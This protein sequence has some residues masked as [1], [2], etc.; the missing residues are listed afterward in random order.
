MSARDPVALKPCPFCKGPPV[1]FVKF[2]DARGQV[3]RDA[4]IE[5]QPEGLFAEAQVFCHECGANGPSHH[6]WVL[7]GDDVD[8]TTREAVLAWN[9]RDERHRDLFDANSKNG[10][11]HWPRL[12]G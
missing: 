12:N 1:P 11:C 10:F 3:V 7:D 9:N 4:R 8:E 2:T 5:A 6:A